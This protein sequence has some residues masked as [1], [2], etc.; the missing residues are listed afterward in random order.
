MPLPLSPK[1]KTEAEVRACLKLL[2]GRKHDVPVAALELTPTIRLQPYAR[3]EGRLMIGKKPGA[4]EAVRLGL[5]HIP[6]VHHPRSFP[7][8]KSNSGKR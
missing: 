7:P 4:K 6:Y 1:I 5:A 8:F 3:V 2:S